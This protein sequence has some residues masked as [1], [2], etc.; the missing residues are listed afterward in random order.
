M[1]PAGGTPLLA[2]LCMAL[3][4]A[5]G[6]VFGAGSAGLPGAIALTSPIAVEPQEPV[7]SAALPASKAWLRDE[8]EVFTAP[9]R[10]RLSGRLARLEAATGNAL[11]VCTRVVPGFEG[12]E[13]LCESLFRTVVKDAGH[14]KVVLIVLG[15]ESSGRAGTGRGKVYSALGAGLTHVLTRQ[16]LEAFL[17]RP[18]QKVT[19]D[20][21]LSG[22]DQLA[23]AL[24]AFARRVPPTAAAITPGTP[25][26]IAALKLRVDLLA[27][28]GT[29]ILVVLLLRRMTRCPQCGARLRKQVKILPAGAEGGSH[30]VR[31]TAKCFT[32]G[33]IRK[34]SLF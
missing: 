25:G 5:S 22:V 4:W 24:E 29:V 11:F 6:P 20:S 17:A 18:G 2:G 31:R 32:C 30:T 3:A 19:T 1:R 33:Y 15:Y 26:P 14:Y 28:I 21:I 34:G 12:F 7:T 10:A 8:A 23:A 9:Q 16:Q 27:G 13:T